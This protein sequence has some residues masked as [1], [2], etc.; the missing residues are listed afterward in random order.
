ME[1]PINSISHDEDTCQNPFDEPPFSPAL[2]EA[3]QAAQTCYLVETPQEAELFSQRAEL[4]P[5]WPLPFER[6][7]DLTLEM[8]APIPRLCLLAPDRVL[9]RAYADSLYA[10]LQEVA[11]PGEYCV[12]W[13]DATALW[14]R[15]L[16][17]AEHRK[18]WRRRRRTQ[19]EPVDQFPELDP[20]AE[21]K[22]A[23]LDG[24]TAKV[25]SW[26]PSTASKRTQEA[27]LIAVPRPVII[28][29]DAVE[30]QAIQWLWPPY[31]PRGMLVML[32]GDPGLGKGLM[33]LQVATNLSR[34][35]P[36]L[37]QLGKPTLAAE[38]EG[39]QVTLI[40][41]AEDSIPHIMIP[42]LDKASADLRY[43]KFLTGW[44][45]P[46]DEVRAFNLQHIAVLI[47]AIEAVKPV[48]VI[49]DPLV[50]YL[51][52]IDMHRSNETRP[53]MANLKDLAE[54]YAC[55]ILGVRHPA[56]MDQ[57][58][59]LMY[60]GQGNVDLIGAARSG[61]WVQPHPT[62]PET[63][64]IMLQSKTNVGPLGRTVIFSRE[65]GLF[66]WK[67]ISRLTESMLTGKG[68]DPWAMLEAFFWLEEYMTPGV[69][70][71]SAPLEK[72]ADE[73][74]ISLKVLNRAKK[75]LGVRSFQ[76]EGAWYCL[77]PSLSTTTKLTGVS[78]FTGFTGSTGYSEPKSST[79]ETNEPDNPG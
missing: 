68:P 23:V 58:S 79:Y 70:Y 10:Y 21:F 40:L 45:G 43:I 25:R 38:V 49:L 20:A 33:L 46:E 76:R 53:I 22:Q 73:R 54:R 63:Q 7:Y 39:P 57:G 34:G 6:I 19:Q 55:T 74:D 27:A 42:R 14:Q 59:R 50:A 15:V 29:A 24:L 31:I 4:T 13:L 3:I 8:I 5:V 71:Q 2:I 77:L 72:R 51:G 26:R 61:L 30:P 17:T 56:K 67:G 48:L 62:H 28:D 18:A 47:Q 69:P 44:L 12:L 16:D 60:R 41:S 64:T 52:D 37:D 78:G 36:F 1:P 32:D 66:A 75:L 65:E 35:L 11:Y 9:N